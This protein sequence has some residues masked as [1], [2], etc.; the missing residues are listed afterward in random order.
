MLLHGSSSNAII[1]ISM[2]LFAPEMMIFLPLA[3][4]RLWANR[5]FPN[6][7][8]V[9]GFIFRYAVH[10]NQNGNYANKFKIRI[11]AYKF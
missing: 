3:F 11:Q 1:M 10:P 2:G 6:I 7:T 9:V 8:Q 4:P 5:V